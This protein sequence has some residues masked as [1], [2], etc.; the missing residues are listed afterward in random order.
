M[1]A[2]LGKALVTLR[3]Q[4]NKAAPARSKVSDGWI[5]DSAHAARKSDHNPNS[6]GVVCALDLTHDPAHGFDASKWAEKLRASGDRRVGY[7]ISN[8]RISS[9]GIQGGAWRKY[10]GI[11]P[12][13]KHFHTSVLQKASAYD[14]PTPWKVDGVI[15]SATNSVPVVVPV[16]KPRTLK[17]GMKGDDVR[18]LQGLLNAAGANPR[19]TVDGGFGQKTHDAVVSFQRKHKFEAKGVLSP[20]GATWKELRKLAPKPLLDPWDK[21][22]LGARILKAGPDFDKLVQYYEAKVT[23]VYDLDGVLHAGYGHAFPKGQTQY[24][25]GDIV[26]D[27]QCELWYAAD[28]AIAEKRLLKHITGRISQR[29]FDAICSIIWNGGDYDDPTDKRDSPL[30]YKTPFG[31]LADAV[32]KEDFALASKVIVALGQKPTASGKIFRGIGLRRLTEDELWRHQPY[33]YR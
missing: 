23:K 30:H 17:K 26:S 21:P 11:N 22:Y 9:P 15:V 25:V 28:K 27:L 4:A 20:D 8:G 12:H 7:L 6:A 19:L 16:I 31:T 13:S 33:Q 5:G 14:D 10:T 2:R 1:A 18:E 32:N 24:K 29:Q 3:D